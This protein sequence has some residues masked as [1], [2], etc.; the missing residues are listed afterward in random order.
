MMATELGAMRRM[1]SS[2]WDLIMRG[3]V[4]EPLI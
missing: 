4:P 1:N 2:S 3:I